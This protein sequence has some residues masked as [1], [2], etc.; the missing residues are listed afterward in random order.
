MD[1]NMIARLP[2]VLQEEE[3]VSQAILKGEYGLDGSPFMSTRELA[4]RCEISLVTAQRVMVALRERG[5]IE[6]TGKKYFLSH[7][8]QLQKVKILGFHVPNIE[9]QYFSSLVKSARRC[10]THRGYKLIVAESGYDASQEKE[11]LD[12]FQELK[13]MGVLSCPGIVEKTGSL[14][15]KYP[16]PIV[17]LGRKPDEFIG[18]SVLVN[19]YQAT[20]KVAEHLIN[21]NYKSFAYIG[22]KEII[23]EDSRLDGYRVGLEK[24]RYSLTKDSIIRIGINEIAKSTKIISEFIL[25]LPKPVGIFC[26]HDLLAV[27]VTRACHM[28]NLNIPHDVAIVGFDDLPIASSLIPT[29]TTV[30]CKIEEMASMAVRLLNN[31]IEGGEI[32]DINYYIEPTLIIRESSTTQ[33]VKVESSVAINMQDMLCTT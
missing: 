27:E 22:L 30:G 17:F 11:I 24:E 19:T 6:L 21:E 29:L 18:Q 13:V 1:N 10:A 15:R 20:R 33:K 5:L 4:S 12:M 14:Y 28:L 8:K 7:G 23:R 2:R 31:Q 16:L 26:F 32:K 9:N 25:N 3:L